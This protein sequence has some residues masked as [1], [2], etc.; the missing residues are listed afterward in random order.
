MDV[1]IELNNECSSHMNGEITQ[2]MQIQ[3][4]DDDDDR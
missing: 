2:Y 4:M 1:I 3:E